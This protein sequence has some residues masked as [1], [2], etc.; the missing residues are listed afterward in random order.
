MD[1]GFVDSVRDLLTALAAGEEPPLPAGG[2]LARVLRETGAPG[3]R[4][5]VALLVDR[6]FRAPT[7]GQAEPSTEPILNRPDL[8]EPEKLHAVLREH[9]VDQRRWQELSHNE[10]TFYRYRR[11]A[12]G[13]FT[14]RLWLEVSERPVVTNRPRPD[15]ARFIGRHQEVAGVLRL[16]TEPGGSVVGI[17]GPGG[18]GKTALLHAVADVCEAAARAWQPLR[19]QGEQAAPLFDAIVWAARSEGVDLA[20]LLEVMARTLDYPGLLS[21][22]IEDRRAALVDL[23]GKRATMVIVDDVDQ[24]EAAVLAFL[25]EL[26]GP[27]RALVSARR[28]LPSRVRALM[29]GPLTAEEVRELLSAEAQRQGVPEVARALADEQAAEPLRA[30]ARYPLLAGWAVGQLRRGQTLERVRERLAGAEGEVFRKMFDAS[31]TSL[32]PGARALL[33]SLLLLPAPA[34]RA[35]L[36]AAGGSGADAALDEL[37]ETSLLEVAGAPT[38][39][40]RRYALHAITRSFV[41]AHLEEASG[42]QRAAVKRLVDHYGALAEDLGGGASN[43]RQF[44]RLEAD[45]RNA[46][47]ILEASALQA[48]ERDDEIPGE[49]FDRAILQLAHGMRNVF[50]FGRAWAE[51]MTL[52]HRAIE[53]ARRL[54]DRRAE[55]WNTYRLGVLHY[56]LGTAG[57]A[58]AARRGREAASL[59]GTAGDLRGRAHA[60]RLLGRATRERG[61]TSDAEQMLVEAE[62]L[63]RRHGLGDDVAIAQASR[64]DLLRAAGRLEEAAALYRD[65]LTRGLDDPGTEANVRN[66]LGE[67]AL[68]H[69]D[70]RE[71]ETFFASAES[72]A[73]AAGARVILARSLL[74]QARVAEARGERDRARRVAQLA[75]DEFERIGDSEQAYEAQSLLDGI[76]TRL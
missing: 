1:T 8:G 50:S 31:V 32:T 18:S 21:Q 27:S 15:Y 54:G 12:I 20:Y 45:L 67:I 9:V 29:P 60:L 41:A 5:A 25:A 59:L 74:G 55:G 76:A 38:D 68:A 35:T 34:D 23:L 26:P 56:E 66:D 44:G 3:T 33:A 16:L 47:A 51:G 46:M 75:V 24:S 39:A 43:W 37:L 71:A 19:V 42:N 48:H 7:N 13:G 61:K 65:V 64:A 17:E 52:F 2:G 40:D 73:Q 10:S 36:L 69:R 30:A 72:L 53:A 57:Y 63:L 49:A 62:E 6:W 28:R 58:E 11:A 14:E 22:A 70:L 4:T